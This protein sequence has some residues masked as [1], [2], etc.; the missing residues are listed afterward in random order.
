MVPNLP[1]DMFYI[2]KYQDVCHL[3][4]M[5]SRIIHKILHKVIFCSDHIL[6]LSVTHY[7]T[8]VRQHGVS[9][10]Y[11]YFYQ[12]FIFCIN[13]CCTLVHVW[14]P[15]MGLMYPTERNRRSTNVL[16]SSFWIADILTKIMC[17]SLTGRHLVRTA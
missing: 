3:I 4:Y 1:K 5:I 12:V 2:V 13:Y 7:L 15:L 8:D 11:I 16:Y 10:I 6:I 14:K 9:L 17:S